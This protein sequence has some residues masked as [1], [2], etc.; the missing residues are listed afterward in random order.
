MDKL[1]IAREN[2]DKIDKE[3]IKLFEM[4][5]ETVKDVLNYKLQNDL[6][7]LDS[8]R[9][10]EVIT[11]NLKYLKS[12]NLEEYYKEFLENLMVISKKYQEE[13]KSNY[14]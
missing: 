2:I 5:M 10:E 14:K 6:E 8:K 12:K 1:K 13:L 3:I 7:I 4:R 9:E 11:K